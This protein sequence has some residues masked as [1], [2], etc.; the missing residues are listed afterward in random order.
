MKIKDLIK[1][2]KQIDSNTEIEIID[3]NDYEWVIMDISEDGLI[4]IENKE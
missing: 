4:W 3:G 2:L 1:K